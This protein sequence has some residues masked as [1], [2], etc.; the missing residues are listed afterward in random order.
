MSSCMRRAVSS[1]L[2]L[3]DR[4]THLLLSVAHTA[5]RPIFFHSS[6]TTR[7]R[8]ISAGMLLRRILCGS[9]P[10]FFRISVREGSF[11]CLALPFHR[12]CVCVLEMSVCWGPSAVHRNRLDVYKTQKKKGHTQNPAG[13]LQNGKYMNMQLGYV[14]LARPGGLLMINDFHDDVVAHIRSCL[15]LKQFGSHR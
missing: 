4:H 8:R 5:L 11:A 2:M 15:T 1:L 3:Q 14:S 13:L 12:T 10:I 6:E 9:I 7:S